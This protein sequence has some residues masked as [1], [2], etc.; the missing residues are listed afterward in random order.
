VCKF[1]HAEAYGYTLV[2]IDGPDV[3][4]TWMERHTK[5]LDIQGIYE[6]R[7]VWSYTLTPELIVLAPNGK[8]KLVAGNPYTIRWKTLGADVDWVTIEY[9][10]DNG[11]TWQQLARGPNTGW[12]EWDRVP[13]MDS[14]Q[15]LV[16]VRAA[17]GQNADISDI[18]DISDE[19][20]TIFECR[21]Q[22]PADLNGDCYVDF[23]DFAILMD[24]WL[25]CGN[26]FDPS[27][28]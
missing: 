7:E 1:N 12:F 28:N 5:D 24:D 4:L 23:R 9:S 20:F 2:E 15:C 3:T 16:R 25:D 21:K 8:E 26:P 18:S 17:N 6:A 11:Q 14:P 10:T 13:I 27:C 19:A 22:M